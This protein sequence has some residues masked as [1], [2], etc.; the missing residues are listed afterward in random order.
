MDILVE[1]FKL[2][3]NV[4]YYIHRHSYKPAVTN[5]NLVNLVTVNKQRNYNVH[6]TSK[7]RM[8]I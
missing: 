5:N 3:I 6:R 7:L 8:N 2:S 4:H 1:I